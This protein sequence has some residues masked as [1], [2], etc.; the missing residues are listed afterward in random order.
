[1]FNLSPLG[2][3]KEPKYELKEHFDKENRF[4]FTD[5]QRLEARLN[6]AVME[7]LVTPSGEMM[8]ISDNIDPKADFDYRILRYEDKARETLNDLNKQ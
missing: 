5:Q 2:W 1:M 7:G 8:D 4:G 6:I 3:N